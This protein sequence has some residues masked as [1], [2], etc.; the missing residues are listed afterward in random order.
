MPLPLAVSLAHARIAL[1]TVDETDVD[2]PA[3]AKD[4]YLVQDELAHLVSADSIGWKIGATSDVAQERLGLKAP[5]AGRVFADTLLT[6]GGSVE[7]TAFHHRP[8][9]ECEIAF[10]LRTAMG[11][12]G[13][14]VSPDEARALVGS[15]HPALELV[16]TRY[17]GGFDVAPGLLVADGSAH[18]ALVM[19]DP[20]APDEAGDLPAAMCRLVVDGEHVAE[21]PGSSVLGDPYVALAWLCNH[22]RGRG[23]G[24]EVGSVI[25]TGTCTGIVPSGPNQ[26]IVNDVGP[27]GR[28]SISIRG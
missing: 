28:V 6:N 2:V 1:A 11:P 4:A 13:G 26:Q 7:A 27:L 22:L 15:V 12:E 10:T 14:Q 8:G 20:V 21:G 24:L 16:G 18:T 17:A 25:T 19:G 5:I 9:I 3:S 23:L